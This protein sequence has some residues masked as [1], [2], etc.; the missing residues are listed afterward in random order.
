MKQA[1]LASVLT[2]ASLSVYAKDIRV[3]GTVLDESGEPMIGATILQKGSTIGTTADIDGNFVLNCD[4][5]GT[6]VISFVGYERQE[7]NVK[8]RTS[9]N[10]VMKPTNENLDE[11]VV[12]GYGTQ[13][14]ISTVGAQSSVKFTGE[15]KQPTANLSSVLAGRVSGV[16]GMQRNGEAGRDDNTEIWVRGVSTT[17]VATP[18]VLVDGVERSWTTIS[19]E[20]I[21]SF[22]ILKDASAT[23]VYGVKGANGVILIQ[24]KKGSKGKPRI[25]VETT[26]GMTNFIQV[27][28]LADGIT[29]MQMANEASMNKNGYPVYTQDYIAKTA[30]GEDPLLYPNV[31]WMKTLFRKNGHN[32]RANVNTSGGSD[33]AQYYFSIGY[34]NE[35]G[36][37]KVRKDERYDGSMNY[38]RVNFV[39][40]LT[41][42]P[43]KTTS[44]EFGVKGEISDYNTPYYS[45]G[46][47]FTAAMK[48][49]PIYYPTK[50][51][52]NRIP[53]RLNGGEVKNPYAMI[54]MMGTNKRNTAETRA[55]L[56]VTQKL[57]FWLPGLEV[58]LLGAYD[59]WSRNDTQ[60]TPGTMITYDVTGRDPI[61][62][63]LIYVRTDQNNGS[64]SWGY[65][66]NSWGHRQYYFEAA[67]QYNQTFNRKHRVSALALFNLTDYSNTT[68]GSLYDAMPYRSIGTAGRVTYSFDDR[69]F[70]EGNFGYNG[71][72]NFPKG[73]RFGFFPSFGLSWVPTHE[74]F[75]PKTEWLDLL[76][77]RGSWGKAGN[78]NLGNS[79][80]FIYL[81]TVGGGG[82][83]KF[84]ADGSNRNWGGV[85]VG[86]PGIDLTWEVATKYNLGLDITLFNNSLN[87]AFDIF[88][89]HRDNI[90][91]KRAAVPDF[92]G[93][94]ELPYGNLGVIENKGY[95]ISADYTLNVDR[96]RVM[97]RGNLSYN[98]NTIIE[99]D[100][101]EKPYAWQNSR[102]HS[103]NSNYGYTCLG[104]LNEK[105]ISDP[106][107]AK[108]KGIK[109]QAGDLRYA[110]LNGDGVIDDYDKG[111]I[112]NPTVPRFTYGF[113]FTVDWNN[114]YIGA[115]FQG[116]GQCDFT[117]S[118][119]NLKPFMDESAKWGLYANI[120]NRWTPEN[121][122]V[123]AEWPRLDYGLVNV[124]NYANSTFWLR[125]GTYVRMKTLDFGY[126]IPKSIT[127]RLKLSSARIFFQG[128]NLLTFSK[129]KLWDPE[130]GQGN[131]LSYPNTRS[132]NLGINF[133]F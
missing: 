95:E 85:S 133:S 70:F 71:A 43:T 50:Y 7:I 116:I 128:Y 19:P 30:S 38:N 54:Y 42:Q 65:G 16:T 97:V 110:D 21:E 8:G 132:Y 127:D 108:L 111:Y 14:K 53:Y 1:L 78:S 101:A 11:V 113:G 87:L 89:E 82:N 100:S 28:D 37:Y 112:G 119:S 29:Y 22:S 123:G 56:K 15:L 40:N 114:W 45:S 31:N 48:A 120:V 122:G 58:R 59:T 55:D 66:K 104:F 93:I 27:P 5:K 109:Q 49:Y 47:I 60:R 51:E 117:I 98:H 35:G 12:V 107:V 81:S 83:F 32:F 74:A 86:R 121:Q 25:K 125:D 102:G 63:E 6:L 18:L 3:V 41:M 57:D 69:Y 68:A 20:D 73:H 10:V 46:D 17:T 105:D 96:V 84:G 77:I 13:R 88:K 75:W 92:I 39:S 94:T 80:R 26:Y 9:I 76:K 34:Y 91:L 131:G 23:A 124:E 67:L 64:D 106:T 4:E 99:D 90:F 33:F 103:L 24:T 2:I 126:N 52:D 129:F 130:V 72:E 62:N 118:A 79:D 61:T 36:M 44:V 115:F